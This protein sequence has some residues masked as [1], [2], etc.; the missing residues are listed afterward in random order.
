MSPDD[1]DNTISTQD[2]L[3]ADQRSEAPTSKI[4]KVIEWDATNGNFIMPPTEVRERI[5]ENCR[6]IGYDRGVIVSMSVFEAKIVA[7]FDCRGADAT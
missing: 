5:D 1:G 6:K 3:A 7:N 4:K 2:T